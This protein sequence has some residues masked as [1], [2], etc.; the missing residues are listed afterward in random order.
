MQGGEDLVPLIRAEKLGQSSGSHDVWIKQCFYDASLDTLSVLSECQ[1][2]KVN[3]LITDPSLSTNQSDGICIKESY[4]A[5]V[6]SLESEHFGLICCLGNI[7]K[8]ILYSMLS[9]NGK[10]KSERYLGK[11]RTCL[12]GQKGKRYTSI[13][14]EC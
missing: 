5:N 12:L 2:V 14:L 4:K 9:E 11:S 13:E 10:K 3:G 8:A 7:I 1:A 6:T